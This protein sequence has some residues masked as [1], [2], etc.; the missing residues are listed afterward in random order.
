MTKPTPQKDDRGHT[1]GP[2]LAAAGPSMHGWPVVN[3]EGRLI[4]RLGWLDKQP[5]E[6]QTEFDRFKAEVAANAALIAASPDLL[7][8]LEALVSRLDAITPP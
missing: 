7:R 2:W 3:G 5:D 4:C 1:P 8:E 6:D